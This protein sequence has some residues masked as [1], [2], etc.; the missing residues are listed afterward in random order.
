MAQMSEYAYAL[1]ESGVYT[2]LYGASRARIK[3]PGRGEEAFILIQETEYPYDGA[4]R[5]T[6]ERRGSSRGSLTVL[7]CT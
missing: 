4:V 3:L 1:D 5:F 7:P 2:V 6:F